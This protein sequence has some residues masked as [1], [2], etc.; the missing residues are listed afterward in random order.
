MEYPL[1]SAPRRRH[2]LQPAVDQGLTLLFAAARKP[3]L[4]ESIVTGCG[5]TSPDFAAGGLMD[6]IGSRD[7]VE[8]RLKGPQVDLL[9]D[10][11]GLS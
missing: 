4:F 8:C 7:S 10:D 11:A 3:E 2:A 9:Y 6:L 5:A 1:A